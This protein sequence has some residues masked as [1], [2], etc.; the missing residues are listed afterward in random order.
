MSQTRLLGIAVAL[1]VLAAVLWGTGLLSGSA[2]VAPPAPIDAPANAAPAPSPATAEAAPAAGADTAA[3]AKT[4][5]DAAA[6]RVAVA[7]GTGTAL[8]GRIVDDKGQP[9]A[10]AEVAAMPDIGGAFE[11][12]GEGVDMERLAQR[13]REREQQRVAVTTDSKGAFRVVPSGTQRGVNLTV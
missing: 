9:V 12:L 13:W 6:A 8:V 10:G 7:P 2:P 11:E 1:V 3:A 4:E 5:A